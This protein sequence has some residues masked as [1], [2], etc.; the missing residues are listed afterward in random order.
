MKTSFSQTATYRC[1]L[2]PFISIILFIYEA[3]LALYAH[4]AFFRPFFGDF[5][6]VI[7]AYTFLKSFFYRTKQYDTKLATGALGVAYFL[8]FLQKIHFLETSGLAKYKIMPMLIGSA[9]SWLDI[10]AYTL[11]YLSI[12]VFLKTNQSR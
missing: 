12:M 6:A 4:D 8:E 7:F 11:G 1:M 2:Y 10:I 5:I 9:F 3:Y